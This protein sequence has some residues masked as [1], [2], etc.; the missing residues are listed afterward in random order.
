M[1]GANSS[2]PSTIEGPGLPNP[3]LLATDTEVLGLSDLST[4]GIALQ[5]PV[6]AV[7]RILA[8]LL[9]VMGWLA[10]GDAVTIVPATATGGGS[11]LLGL[12]SG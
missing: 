5:W 2:S 1:A 9:G 10:I 3:I 11:G 8:R 6:G 7:L 12:K 4:L